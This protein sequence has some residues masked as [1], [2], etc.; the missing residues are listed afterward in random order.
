MESKTERYRM[1]MDG[2]MRQRQRGERKAGAM[3][4]TPEKDAR[5][6]RVI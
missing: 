1:K 6:R 3:G 5:G 2:E 4:C